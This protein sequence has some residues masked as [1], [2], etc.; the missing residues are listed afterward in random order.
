MKGL[1]LLL[2]LFV[3][4]CAST[5]S[6]NFNSEENISYPEKNITVVKRLGERLVSKSSRQT[7][8]AISIKNGAIIEENAFLS[9]NWHS[10]TTQEYFINS[11]GK[12]FFSAGPFNLTARKKDGTTGPA[13]GGNQARWRICFEADMESFSSLDDLSK[14]KPNAYGFELSNNCFTRLNPSQINIVTKTQESETNFKQEFVYNGR[15]NDELRF[16]F[17]EFYA[18]F[19]RPAFTQELV[20]DLNISK[21]I[22]FRDLKLKIIEATNLEIKYQ[23]ISNF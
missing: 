13:C 12:D 5:S 19:A 1:I 21:D 17:R 4:S 23:V 16:I 9:C 11:Q 10:N 6:V 18:D 15:I 14:L 7:G 22:G 20:Y 3:V 8:P 2:S